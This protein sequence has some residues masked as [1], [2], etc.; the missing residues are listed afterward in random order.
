MVLDV[1]G[2]S[3]AGLNGIPAV[4]REKA[5]AAEQAGRLV[6]D[7]VRADVRPSAII[8]HD[9]L[10]NAV[11]ALAASGGSTNG[12]LHLL[13][14][15]REL[16][17]SLELDDFDRIAERTPVLASLKPGGA[18]VA[19]DLYDAGG[20]AL[21]TR[22]LLKRDLVHAGAGNVD[23]RDLAQIAAAAQERP[24]QQVV[25]PIDRP[26]KPSGGLAILRGNLAPEGAVVKLVGH[27]RRVHRGPARVFESRGGLLRRRQGPGRSTPATS[28]SSATRARPAGRECARC[29]TS[30]RPS[31]ARAWARRWR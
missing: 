24:G 12:V 17:L 30:R 26:I 9:A 7:L 16:G 28:S 27:E 11:A 14:I 6:M 8:T 13:A 15:A 4:R 21:V 29:C 5:E 31:S 19:T 20:V 2:I 3:P 18:Y 23:G 10:E 25:V 1:L 22:E